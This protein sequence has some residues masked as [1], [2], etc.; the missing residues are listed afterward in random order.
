MRKSNWKYLA[1]LAMGLAVCPSLAQ[2]QDGRFEYRSENG[3]ERSNP[4]ID[5]DSIQPGGVSDL[6]TGLDSNTWMRWVQPTGQGRVWRFEQQVRLRAYED[7]DDLNS[8]LLTPRI[9]Y[10]TPIGENWQARFTGAASWLQR[11]GETHYTRLEGEGQLRHR[12]TST[13][14]TVLRL[15]HTAYDFGNQVVA[16]LDQSQWRAGLERH[17]FSEDRRE[18][19]R[20]D[21]YYK[22]SDAD[23]DRFS[24]DEWRARARAWTPL[25]ETVT[26]HVQL[27]LMERDYDAAFSVSEPFA[28]SD[29]RWEIVA[30]AERPVSDRVSLYGEAGYVDNDSNIASRTYSG[31][32]FRIG[33]RVEG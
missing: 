32:V 4:F 13:G 6:E 21:L 28:R 16:G 23:A 19:V 2:A 10:W 17:W 9:Q 14:E 3:V 22:T 18:G 30:G 15:R 29:T 1:G 8:I 26:G 33:F 5:S 27:E 11:D 7:R 25:G 12:P 20:V 31:A 24:H